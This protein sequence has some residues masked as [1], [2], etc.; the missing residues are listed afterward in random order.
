MFHSFPNVLLTHIIRVIFTKTKQHD[1]LYIYSI[2]ILSDSTSDGDFKTCVKS[3]KLFE[4]TRV[5]ILVLYK[6]CD[7]SYGVVFH[8]II[9][10][11]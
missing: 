6:Q 3:D 8:R 1:F 7:S 9:L 2:K 5:L 4:V 11:Y 10:V